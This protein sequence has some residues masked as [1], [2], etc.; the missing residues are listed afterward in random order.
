MREL[1]IRAHPRALREVVYIRKYTSFFLIACIACIIIASALM[2]LLKF[3]CLALA[4]PM[5]TRRRQKN[6]IRNV[7]LTSLVVKRE[8]AT[9]YNYTKI[10]HEIY[11]P[12][13]FSIIR[14][15]QNFIHTKFFTFTVN[16]EVFKMMLESTF[17]QWR[18]GW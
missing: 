2:A 8:V 5:R 18:F 7:K 14:N 11:Y 15:V 12:R 3:L 1:T 13:K 6:Q 9:W 16:P 10:K 4:E 17:T